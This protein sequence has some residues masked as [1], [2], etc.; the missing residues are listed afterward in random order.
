MLMQYFVLRYRHVKKAFVRRGVK[1]QGQ[2]HVTA[3][4][5]VTPT[6]A[7]YIHVYWHQHRENR[8]R[9]IVVSSSHY[10]ILHKLKYS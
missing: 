4:S 2:Y 10:G 1:N 6:A 8:Y 7:I 5:M 9:P 3:E